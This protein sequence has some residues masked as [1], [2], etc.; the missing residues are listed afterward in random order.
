M[1]PSRS[2]SRAGDPETVPAV[3]GSSTGQVGT[4]QA[5]YVDAEFTESPGRP[6]RE[7]F[8][9][10]AKY[11]WL[12]A[13]AFASVLAVAVLQTL[14][15]TRIYVASTKLE[16][17]NE[18]PIQLRLKDD[19]LNL[20]DKG[21]KGPRFFSTQLAI[22]RSRDLAERVIRKQRLDE[23][24]TFLNPTKERGGVLEVGS[25]LI[26]DVRPRG[27]PT[28]KIALAEGE[29]TG[30]A[31]AD[32]GIIDRYVGY[33]SIA[34]VKGTDLVEVSFSTPNPTLSAMLSAAHSQAYL[35]S[36][37][38]MKMETDVEAR[39][40]L[41]RQIRR[42]RDQVD[43]TDSLLNTF[44][45]DHP[46][47]AMNEEYKEF[48]DRLSQYAKVLGD[49]EAER[50]DLQS[51]HDFLTRKGIDPF[52]Y[53]AGREG[54]PGTAKLHDALVDIG[55]QKSSL[56]GRL[57]PNHPQMVELTRRE[58]ETKQQLAQELQREISSVRTRLDAAKGKEER[59]R[60]ALGRVEQSSM[61]LQR[62]GAQY[63][64]LKSDADN[65]RTM[66]DALLKQQTS[67]MVRS[68]LD[69][70]PARVVERAE[71]PRSAAKP[72]VRSNLNYGFLMGLAAA[73]AAILV[74]DHFDNSVKTTKDIEGL[75]QLAALATIP[76][77]AI[78][79][80]V[81]ARRRG[82]L[83][84]PAVAVP[85]AR[86]ESGSPSSGPGPLLVVHHEPMSVIAEAFRGLR[87]NI[88]FST[89]G[90]PPKVIMLASAGMSEGKTVISTNLAATLAESGARVLL[91]D[92]D[93]RHASCHPHI[94]VT[95]EVGLST[96]LTGRPIEE[97]I[98][99][100]DAPRLSFISAGPHPPNPAELVGS[101][102]MQ[103]ALARLRDE[104]DFIIIDSPAL[105]PVTD[106]VVLSRY[107]DGV[108][109]VVKAQ[110]TSREMV[111]RARDLLRVANA[112]MLGAVMN[113]VDVGSYQYG[114]Y[115]GYYYSS[116]AG[117]ESGRD[118]AEETAG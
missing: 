56:A 20:D 87:T 111:I 112:H 84:V 8:E 22:L 44:R 19:V 104:Y 101:T 107:S 117:L 47:V 51:Q 118:D 58:D 94:G 36:A 113:N 48:G 79:R 9:L 98:R 35:E 77:F 16:I 100:I 28:K 65:A 97:V 30:G 42:A 12:A 43:R 5:D 31:E 88:L 46:K 66:H 63:A 3:R 2:I 71:V 116:A 95:N 64:M 40:F 34:E 93:M 55:I 53:F 110:D 27:L 59:A 96:F 54:S 72:N 25:E 49:A 81:S 78:A 92:A 11:R 33:L 74:A 23:N 38:E 80:R 99:K 32:P 61:E 82:R 109:L 114:G 15:A 14:M 102:R 62:L 70:T 108:I 41:D 69:T 45:L 37:A 91:I 103:E 73:L 26:G 24:E 18:A 7:Y 13:A 85:E 67:T 86:T 76:N 17:S 75:L 29:R 4:A 52:F 1:G 68:Q 21:T 106:G 83:Q 90:A 89:A 6:L 57:G 105:L 60:E 10:I 115:Y 39:G 50:I